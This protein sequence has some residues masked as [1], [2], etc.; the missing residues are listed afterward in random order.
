MKWNVWVMSLRLCKNVLLWVFDSNFYIRNMNPS[1]GNRERNHNIINC[2]RRW[3]L[4]S[5][6]ML[7]NNRKHTILKRKLWNWLPRTLKMRYNYY[8]ISVVFN[9]C[10]IWIRPLLYILHHV[11]RIPRVGFW[12]NS[13]DFAS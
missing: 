6:E 3:E 4:N 10:N 5:E 9:L 1:F 11:R 12:F 7:L 8:S 2:I 13:Q